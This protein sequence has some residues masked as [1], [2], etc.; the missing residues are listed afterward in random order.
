MFPAANDLISLGTA[1]LSYSDLFLASGGVI[2]WNNGNVTLTHAS[3]NLSLAGNFKLGT[4]GNGL[5]IKEGTNATMG[6]ATMV[7]GTVTISTTKVTANSRIYLTVQSL[8][9]V[10]VATPIA[11]TTRSA[12]T[13]F[14]IS[15]SSATDTSVVAW[16][17]VEPA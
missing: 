9:T 13:S 3:G 6:V 17:I 2:N 4:A 5:Y 7:L 10:A 15:S 1:T 14:T 12:G 8:G 16:M 11:V